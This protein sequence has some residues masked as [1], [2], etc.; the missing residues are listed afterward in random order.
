MDSLFQRLILCM[1]TLHLREFLCKRILQ[2]RSSF[3]EIST[4]TPLPPWSLCCVVFLDD[5]HIPPP[6]EVG[7]PPEDACPAAFEMSAP[8]VQPDV[9]T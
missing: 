3:S 8:P 5:T 1:E 9:A 4:I 7:I 2:F 6:G